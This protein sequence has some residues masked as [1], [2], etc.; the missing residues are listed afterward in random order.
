MRRL[1]ALLMCLL[2]L[3]A[4]TGCGGSQ[5]KFEELWDQ[6]ISAEEN[7]GEGPGYP[8]NGY[9]EGGLGDTMH[10]C[11]F[12]FTVSEAYCT[13]TFQNYTAAGDCQL[14]VAEITVVGT[15]PSSITM[16]DVDFQAQ[17]DGTGEEDFALPLTGLED[18]RVL[19]EEY[20]LATGESRTGLLVFEVPADAAP[21]S[22]SLS[23]LELFD[24]D[25]EGDVFFVYFTADVQ[26][27]VQED[28]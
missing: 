24:D 19:P 1:S 15:F 12:D 22:F 23:Y 13:D 18:D 5:E 8:Q 10:T 2:L 20:E 3:A 27:N 21:D 7:A 26:E 9:A 11:F 28:L 25:T 14:L 16:Y 17:W 4:L 6:A